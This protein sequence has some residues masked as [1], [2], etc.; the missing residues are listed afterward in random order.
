MW[1]ILPRAPVVNLMVA[2]G[3]AAGER[4]SR[5]GAVSAEPSVS[6][7]HLGVV[8]PHPNVRRR[9]T[10]E[11]PSKPG[12]HWPSGP[13]RE[14]LNGARPDLERETDHDLVR[15]VSVLLGCSCP[16]LGR[17]PASRPSPH[18]ATLQGIR[19]PFLP[20]L[21][22]VGGSGSRRVWR[23]V[24]QN[25]AEIDPVLRATIHFL[26]ANFCGFFAVHNRRNR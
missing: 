18:F 6:V 1:P 23:A 2:D 5:R 11:P 7:R 21:S 22:P 16:C 14:G 9:A 15:F 8:R 20:C 13:E 17:P 26:P 24:W 12:Q 10:G 3:A 25:L 4:P 19:G